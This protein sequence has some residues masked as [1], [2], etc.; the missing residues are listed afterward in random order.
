MI[1][2]GTGVAPFRSFITDSL[3]SWDKWLFFGCRNEKLDF[4]FQ[5]EWVKLEQDNLLKFKC[6]FSRDSNGEY[7]YVMNLFNLTFQKLHFNLF[8]FKSFSRKR[9][10]VQ[11]KILQETE[12]LGPILASRKFYIYVAG[13]AKDMPKD[14]QEAILQLMKQSGINN[15]ENFME[16]CSKRLGRYQTETWS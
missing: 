4:Y 6:A 16:L 12:T 9:D 8:Y 2:P 10:Y 14:V 15:A 13:N 1:G 7:V 11:D 5:D 3:Q